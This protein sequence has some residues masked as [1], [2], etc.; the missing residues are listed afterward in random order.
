MLPIEGGLAADLG[1]HALEG[2]VVERQH[3]VA[4]GLDEE[5]PLQLVQ[6]LGVLLGEVAGLGPVG[7]AVVE[8]P[9]VVVEGDA[10]VAGGLPRRAVLGDRRPAAV[11]DAAVAE[12]LEVL[13]LVALGGGRV[14]EAVGH[15]RALHRRL[16]DAVDQGRLRQIPAASS[17]VGATSM[18]WLN[19]LRISPLASM[20]F[21]QCTIVPLRVPPQCE[22]TCLVHWYGVHIACA[23]PT[24]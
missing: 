9:D 2:A 12:D 14:V 19:W 13:R 17:T 10:D 20:P 23:Q 1:Q 24:A 6:L 4:G 11:V 8:L 3:V 5:E 15:A 22:A 21:G 18:T 16:G 7:G